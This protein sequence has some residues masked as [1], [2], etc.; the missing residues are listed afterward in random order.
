MQPRYSLS[1]TKF[2]ST[3]EYERLESVLKRTLLT[4]QSRDAIILFLALRT[5]A[6]AQEILNLRVVDFS[7]KHR[8][9]FVRGLKG[10]N[11][12]EIPIPDWLS[13]KIEAQIQRAT[14]HSEDLIFPIT[15]NR[16][17][18]I[19]YHYRPVKKKFHSLRHTFAYRIFEHTKDI[20]L[21]QLSLGHRSIA[22]TMIYMDYFYG[23]E[24]MRRILDCFEPIKNIKGLAEVS[25]LRH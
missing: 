20:K 17:A 16:L 8:T 13:S 21:V 19:W 7:S 25:H 4:A 2:L 23:L 9:V 22:N 11:D 6:R 10:S 24:Q 5:G 1:R 12:R 14:I 3:D 15:Y 18:Q